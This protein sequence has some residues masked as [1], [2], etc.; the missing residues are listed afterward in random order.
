[1]LLLRPALF[2]IC[3]DEE[4][5]RVS[6]LPVRTLNLL[7]AV[8]TAVT[9]TI[10]MR[11]VGLLLV[12]ALMV[13]PVAA[14][15]QV[16]RGF[17]GTMAA[18]DGARLVAAGA[19]VVAGRPR[20]NTAPGATIVI[21]A[22][23]RLRRRS[24]SAGGDLAAAAPPD[25]A[26]APSRRGRSRPD[27]VLRALMRPV[28]A[29]AAR[30]PRRAGYEAYEGAG[31][32]LRALAAPI[33]VAIVTELGA[34]ER[35]VHELVEKLGAPQPLVSQHL[36]VLRGAGVVRGARRGREIAYSLVDEHIAHIVADAV[37]HAREARSMNE[38]RRVAQH[39][40]A[41]RGQRRCSAE[42]EGF[43]SA[44]ELHAML[45]DRGERVGLTT[46]YRTLQ[47][48]ADAGEI[49]V[50]RPPGGEHLYR[51]CSQGH[52]HHLVC[53]SCGR[54]VEVEGPAVETLGRPGGRASTASSTSP[55]PGDL[56]YLPGALRDVLTCGTLSGVKI[57][58]DRC[59]PRSASCSPTCS[60]CLG[61]RLDPGRAS[62]CT[63]W[64]R[65][66]ACRARSWRAPA[67]AS[68]TTWP[69]PAAR[70]AG[71]RS[72]ATS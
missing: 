63:T 7:L 33:R 61:L 71:C 35:C 11:T 48:L 20:S 49:D 53:R 70:W 64:S 10:A 9:V 41:Q 19:G 3:H 21:L 65:S 38:P 72:S 66:S 24:P 1:M 57:Y 56:R 8:T 23:R 60:W 16:T 59:P 51:R 29:T 37:S 28:L 46:V 12:S 44:Q 26:A 30:R 14:A 69:T 52:H 67:P 27:V 4:Y 15:Q 5:A 36:R 68:P 13:V 47:G 32:L 25:P 40:A 18:G 2:A 54:T 34:G 43:H 39:P 22:H 50:M 45:R 17:R 58:A 42:A 55:H 6:G 62:G 31:E